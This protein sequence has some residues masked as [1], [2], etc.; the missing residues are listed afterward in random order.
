L[1]DYKDPLPYKI[2]SDSDPR[3][4]PKDQRRALSQEEIA[5][6]ARAFNA[7]ALSQDE[8]AV[9]GYD[10][11]HDE[12]AEALRAGRYDLNWDQDKEIADRLDKYRAALVEIKNYLLEIGS[13]EDLPPSQDRL[14]E[15][16]DEALK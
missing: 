15:I 6:Y 11:S 5:R 16:V 14:T 9:R 4:T 10:M 8:I 12:L 13:Y 2:V 1:S 3:L 7:R